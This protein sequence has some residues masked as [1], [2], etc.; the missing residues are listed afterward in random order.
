MSYQ[1]SADGVASKAKTWLTPEQIEE[2]RAES[3]EFGPDYLQDRDETIVVLL[4]DTGVRVGEL[5]ALKWD[6]VDKEAGEL[7]LPGPIQKGT[8][9]PPAYLDLAPDTVRQLIRFRRSRYKETEKILF[10][11]QSDSMTTEAVRSRVRRLAV[12]ADVRPHAIDTL[13]SHDVVDGRAP[14]E[15]VTPH[16][17]RHSIAYRLIRRENKRLEDVQLRLRHKNRETT[18]RIYSHLRTR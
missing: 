1:E 12:A 6:Y 15:A 13:E 16:T 14:P 7:Y 4:A 11:R 3:L 5:V 8:N 18:D 17:F 2:I 9:P 10:S